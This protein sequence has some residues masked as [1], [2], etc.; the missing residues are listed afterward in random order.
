MSFEMNRV[1]PGVTHIRDCMGVCMTLI[2]G[3][4]SALLVDTGY[5]VESVGQMLRDEL[6]DKP[7]HV[8]LTHHHHD[9]ALGVRTLGCVPDCEYSMLE[10]DAAAFMRYCGMEKRRAVLGQARAK[11]LA[12]AEDEFLSG[13]I[14]LPQTAQPGVIDLGGITAVII[15]CPG[16]TPGSAAVLIPERRIL[17]TADC[18]NPCT[19]AFFPEALGVQELRRNL[20]FL[21][22]A[23]F[24]HVLCG[25]Q[26]EMYPRRKFDDFVDQLT[27]ELL[28]SAPR[29]TMGGYEQINTRQANVTDGQILVFDWDKADL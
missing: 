11:G 8:F 1:A 24:D 22:A 15:D 23:A 19:W 25:H 7:V 5:G 21:Q 26:L 20:R 10:P 6:G 16:H 17:L 12:V 9:H 27:D 4:K 29:V 14:G 2:E 18:W 13:E 28:R 3:E